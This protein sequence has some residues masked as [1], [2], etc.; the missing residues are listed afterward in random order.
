MLVN[1]IEIWIP[2]LSYTILQIIDS[3]F[4]N[5]TTKLSNSY[6]LSGLSFNKIGNSS[7]LLF[8]LFIGLQKQPTEA[9]LLVYTTSFSK[10]PSHCSHSVW[11]SQLIVK[12]MIYILNNLYSLNMIV[13]T[14]YHFNWVLQDGFHFKKEILNCTGTV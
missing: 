8:P 13:I 5:Y 14:E 1:I 11:S 3:Q 2:P 12:I 9:F 10:S 6:C 4:V 7:P